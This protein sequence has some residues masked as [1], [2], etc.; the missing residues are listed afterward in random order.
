MVP[1]SGSNSHPPTV[2]HGKRSPLV[3]PVY[4]VSAAAAAAAAALAARFPAFL[5][6]QREP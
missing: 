5:W 4:R 3:L 2:L 1:L 6:L